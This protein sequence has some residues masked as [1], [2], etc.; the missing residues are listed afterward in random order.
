MACGIFPVGSGG[1]VS[2]LFDRPFYQQGLDGVM[3][4]EPKQ[5][6]S[7][8]TTTP[9][10]T[11]LKLPANFA[12]RNVPDISAN[13]DP[14]TGYSLFY[15]SDKHGFQIEGFGGGTSFVAPQLAGVTV[16]LGESLRGRVGLL[17]IP[18]Y[19]LAHTNG[20]KGNDAPLKAIKFG[21]NEFYTGSDGYNPGA[22]LGVLDVGQL[23]SALKK[24]FDR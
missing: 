16:L 1:G 11:I 18:L 17:N 8:N 14:D 10:T 15:T 12:G 13:A 6:L 24:L 21:N 20:Y 7:D 9:P 22:G 23:N 3:R 2:V 5:V 4:S 19:Y